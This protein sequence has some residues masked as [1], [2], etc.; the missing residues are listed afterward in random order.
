MSQRSEGPSETPPRFHGALAPLNNPDYRRLLASNAL[1]WQFMW[2][3]IIV[4]G[5]LV[6]ELTNSAWQVSLIGFYRM[7]PLLLVGFVSGPLTDRFGRRKIIIFSQAV[8]LVVSLL[9]ALIILADRLAVW[10]LAVGALVMGTTWAADWTARR[11]LLPDLVGKARTMDAML[12]EGI[13]QNITRVAG[14]FSSG[15]LYATLEPFG[16]YLILTG[17]ALASLL[18]LVRL[19]RQPVL[20][21]TPTDASHWTRTLE[22]LRYIRRNPVI[23]GVTLITITMNFLVFPYQTLLPVF[24]RDILDQGPVGFG[25]LASANGVGAFAGLW[26]VSRLRRYV[27]ISW[28]YAAGSFL[29][30]AAVVVFSMSADFYLSFGLL[31]LS[32][33]GHAAFGLLQSTI[34][35]LSARDDMRSRAMGGIVLAI[36]TGPPGRLSAGALAERFGAPF[37]VG[38]TCAIAALFVV[39]VTLAMSGFRNAS[40]AREADA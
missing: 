20:E 23:L 12:L 11:S 30:A 10:H 33:I 28:L 3:E 36:G 31:I 9:I 29:M 22:G 14:P 7:A 21:R 13:F 1:W 34:V 6:L 26:I 17:I 16:C 39:A 5:W 4:V 18:I 32:G 27:S 15:A 37:A 19:S 8:N 35:L 40:A 25:V 24:A 38:L 2:M